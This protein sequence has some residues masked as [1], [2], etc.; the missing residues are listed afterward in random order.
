GLTETFAELV[1]TNFMSFCN[2]EP[3]GSRLAQS[4]HKDKE[5]SLSFL[6]CG[7]CAVSPVRYARRVKNDYANQSSKGFCAAF[8]EVAKQSRKSWPVGDTFL[9]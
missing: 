1:C 7:L 9:S 4:Q 6:W 8:C 2:R 3:L 5:S